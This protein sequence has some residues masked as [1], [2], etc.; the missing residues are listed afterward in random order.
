MCG[1]AGV[2]GHEPGS[3][4]HLELVGRMAA[5]L[6]HRGPDGVG[7]YEDA[8][9][10]VA[11][12]HARLA[13]FDLSDAGRQPFASASGRF[14]AT[15]NGEVFNHAELRA[16]LEGAGYRFKSECDTEVLVNAF[17]RWG[18][19]G[20]VER[21]NGMFAFGVWDTHEKTLTLG[22][23]RLGIKPLYWGRHQGLLCF[24]SDLAAIRVVG[25]SPNVDREA[26]AA[27]FMYGYVPW[28][29]CILEGF[30]KVAPGSLLTFQQPAA[31]PTVTDYWTHNA[32]P[33]S[34]TSALS[35][36]ATADELELLLS[37]SVRLRL[38]AD[39]PVGAFLSGGVDSS[40][41]VAL[42]QRQSSTPI[43]TYS[44][45]FEDPRHDE[46]TYAAR[47]A[48][49]LG[50]QHTTMTVG[51]RE[52]L[53]IIPQLGDIY[54]E[55]FADSSQVPTYLVSKLARTEVTVALSGD[56]GDELF[57]GYTRYARGSKL[58]RIAQ[59]VPSPLKRMVP[60]LRSLHALPLSEQKL[61]VLQLARVLGARDAR[62]VL[63]HFQ[64]IWKVPDAIV[65]C[66]HLAP[67]WPAESWEP[68]DTF[69]DESG[70][71]WMV[72]ADLG[73]YLPG[74]IL[75]KVDR[76]SMACSLEAR[77]PL[78]DYRVVEFALRQPDK[79][80]WTGV[81]GSKL[82]L[83][84]VLSRHVP[85]EMSAR[86]KM[87]FGIPIHHWLH[88]EL[89]DWAESLL[90]E[91]DIRRDGLLHWNAVDKLWRRHKRGDASTHAQIWCVLMF[92][93][94]HRAWKSPLAA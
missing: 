7:T 88:H 78:L 11:L 67:D 93:A 63:Q 89:R 49:H 48:A 35:A 37:D 15:Y 54:T 20:A 69:G 16:D 66:V 31:P 81:D 1:I 86:P 17:E 55:P 90:D 72:R 40:T 70:T 22:R 45:G 56:G 73:G 13:I 85:P 50:T 30:H 43:R 87:G 26:L 42:A 68:H 3:A 71:E 8:R 61:R 52:A 62:E 32:H 51:A 44:I 64:T 21:C 74:D 57:A 25:A 53:A 27:Y 84:T 38:A 47:I 60:D 80:R 9:S 14:V 39:V 75:T 79:R 24:A 82:P 4:P 94:W 36:E 23:D 83:R 29:R 28:E 65:R 2:W 5:A 91:A 41:V 33:P 77:V 34:Q 58:W 59:R 12:A 6:R 10:Q 76:A 46:S 18:V 92:Q 19:Q